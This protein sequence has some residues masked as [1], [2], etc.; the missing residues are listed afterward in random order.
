[1]LVAP[2]VMSSGSTSTRDFQPCPTSC[3]KVARAACRQFR[4]EAR[5][6]R[7]CILR[8]EKYGS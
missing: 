2:Y 1:M 5:R 6:V 4:K 8:Q 3:A 7:R